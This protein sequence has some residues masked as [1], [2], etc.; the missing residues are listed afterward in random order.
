MHREIRMNKMKNMEK[1][2]RSV[3]VLHKLI[4]DHVAL[5]EK[6]SDRI[7]QKDEC[8]FLWVPIL[9]YAVK[10]WGHAVVIR[11]E[12][13]IPDLHAKLTN[14]ITEFI[15]RSLLEKLEKPEETVG[16]L[17]TESLKDLEKQI[18]EENIEIYKYV[19]GKTAE[20]KS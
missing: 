14:F 15:E 2:S 17:F 4:N 18:K 8:S 6:E 7:C 19:T 16:K 11:H 12:E 20:W 10:N 5:F 13:E 1:A 3:E 9:K